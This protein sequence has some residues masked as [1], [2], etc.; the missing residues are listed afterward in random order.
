ME[1]GR[2]WGLGGYGGE[3]GEGSK[4]LEVLFRMV[5]KGLA[6]RSLTRRR[7]PPAPPNPPQQTGGI[8]A[9]L[10]AVISESLFDDLDHQARGPACPGRPPLLLARKGGGG[11]S[12][13]R[14]PRSHLH[15]P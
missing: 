15:L 11:G 9:S 4:V 8:G 14:A 12:C 5:C 2:V 3:F 10:S 7:S 1:G 6:R 13:A